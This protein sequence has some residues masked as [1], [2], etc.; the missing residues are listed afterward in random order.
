MVQRSLPAIAGLNCAMHPDTSLTGKH[1]VKFLLVIIELF[2][3]TVTA[4]VL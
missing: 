1:L 3:V 2:S 4:E